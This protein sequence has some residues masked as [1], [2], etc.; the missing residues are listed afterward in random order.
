[1]S[2]TNVVLGRRLGW[3]CGLGLLLASL[4][5]AVFDGRIDSTAATGGTALCVVPVLVLL[6][7][8]PTNLVVNRYEVCR[9]RPASGGDST[10]SHG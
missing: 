6:V 5:P 3:L 10:R 4:H 9:R 7:R 1:M 8:G 2:T